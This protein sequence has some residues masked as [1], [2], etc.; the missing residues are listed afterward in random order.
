[1]PPSGASAGVPLYL[2]AVSAGFPSPADDYVETA[3]DLNRYL[4][5]NP[6]ATFM[7]RVGGDSMVDAGILD[8]DVLVVDRSREPLPGRIVVAVL[9]GELTVKR[10]CRLQGRIFLAPENSAYRPIEVRED[11]ELT[12]WGV[13]TG[14]IRKL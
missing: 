1:M 3:L 12:V 10:L 9:D 2:D 6:A 8:G 13:V 7:V 14:V 5:A 4:V 11:Q